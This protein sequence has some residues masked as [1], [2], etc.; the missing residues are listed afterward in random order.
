MVE[1]PPGINGDEASIGYNAALISKTLHDENNKFLPLFVL[2]LDQKDWKQPVTVYSTAIAFKIFGTSFE[3]LRG[4]SVFYVLISASLLFLLIRELTSFKLALLG[5][6]IFVTTPIIIIHSHLALEN[7]AP[8]PFVILWALMILKYQKA[9]QLKYLLFAG[10]SLG[11]STYSYNGMRLIVP[12]IFGLS[13]LY[14]YY[15]QGNVRKL[16]L[17]VVTFLIGI[18]PFVLILPIIKSNYPGAIYG[19]ARPIDINSFQQFIMPYLSSY[20]LSFLYIT[21]DTTPYHSSEHGVFLL[22]TLP[23]FILGLINAIKNKSS[24]LFLLIATFFL[25]PILYGFVGSIHRASRLMILI[26]LYTVIVTNG[27][28]SLEIKKWRKVLVIVIT[29]IFLLNF[30][31]FIWDYWNY[32]PDRIKVHFP[33]VADLAMKNLYEQ[34]KNLRLEPAIEYGVYVKEDVAARFFEQVYFPKTL[35]KWKQGESLPENSIMLIH[36]SDFGIYEKSGFRKLD[37]EMPHYSL[38]VR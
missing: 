2:T 22:I 34:S 28:S 7:I 27:I 36:A 13:V 14:L 11:L 26:P 23:F 10:I 5:V 31:N 37:I 33:Y 25:V 4:V 3:T 18:L 24:F 1:V 9:S 32:Y 29:T 20:D 8:L 19:S 21:G 16:V 12:V 17:P 15:L 6:T 35:K 38:I 30:Y